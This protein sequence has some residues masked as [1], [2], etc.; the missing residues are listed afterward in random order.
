MTAWK[1]ENV[2][3]FNPEELPNEPGKRWFVRREE[4]GDSSIGGVVPDAGFASRAGADQW[5]IDLGRRVDWRA[6][7]LFHLKGDS[8]NMRIVDKYGREPKT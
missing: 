7:F 2:D 1:G 3:I 5:I 8:K 6:G 4:T